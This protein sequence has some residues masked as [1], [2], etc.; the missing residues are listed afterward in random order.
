MD[1]VQPVLQPLLSKLRRASTNVELL[2]QVHDYRWLSTT[3]RISLTLIVV[4]WGIFLSQKYIKS[5][6]KANVDAWKDV[7]QLWLG[8]DVNGLLIFIFR[9]WVYTILF[10]AAIGIIQRFQAV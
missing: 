7:N 2:K 1:Q 8:R 3:V 4:A 10:S 9:V 6:D 5:K